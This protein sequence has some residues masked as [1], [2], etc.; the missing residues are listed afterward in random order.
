[1]R[2]AKIVMS[3]FLSVLML[4]SCLVPAFASEDCAHGTYEWVIDDNNAP[5]CE[6]A[7]TMHLICTVCGQTIPGTEGT[8]VSATGHSWKVDEDYTE[9]PCMI[10]YVCENE[11]C[12]VKVK[13]EKKPDAEHSWNSGEISL[14]P[15]CS[16]D[17]YIVYTCLFCGTQRSEA[18]PATDDHADADKNGQCDKCG[19]SMSYKNSAGISFKEIF[20]SFWNFFVNLFKR[21]GSLFS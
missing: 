11:N 2:K 14:Q 16:S 17:G 1:M 4:L 19:V 8:V 10:K 13:F 18:T 9:A 3:L 6:K 21:I 5:S 15:T 20:L 7:G 12:E